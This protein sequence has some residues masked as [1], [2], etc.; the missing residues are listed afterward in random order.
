MSERLQSRLLLTNDRQLKQRGYG[1]ECARFGRTEVTQLTSLTYVP[2]ERPSC[3]DGPERFPRTPALNNV[4]ARE[5][6][7]LLAP[8]ATP[9]RASQT[10]PLPISP[11][12]IILPKSSSLLLLD[13]LPA[14]DRSRRR[15]ARWNST[16]RG[17]I[18]LSATRPGESPRVDQVC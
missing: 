15:L 11:D 16:V 17:D 1:S 18:P 10:H 5:T 9:D 12:A 2:A 3:V 13:R 6:G 7:R 14:S 4:R 8:V